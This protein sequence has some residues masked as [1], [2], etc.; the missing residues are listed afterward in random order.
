MEPHF[1]NCLAHNLFTILRGLSQLLVYEI[2]SRIA[3]QAVSAKM[4]D[5][6]QMYLKSKII[7]LHVIASTMNVLYSF[8]IA[9]LGIKIDAT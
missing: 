9:S 3:L 6:H 4:H 5:K 1:P 7:Q 2:P 8:T